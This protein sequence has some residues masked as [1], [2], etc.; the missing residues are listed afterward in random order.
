[1]IRSFP[2]ISR[3][4]TILAF[5]LASQIGAPVAANADVAAPTTCTVAGME[6]YRDPI[7]VSSLHPSY[8]G[9]SIREVACAVEST[10]SLRAGD[11]GI[12]FTFGRLYSER[13]GGPLLGV[14]L[15]TIE[16]IDA[17]GAIMVGRVLLGPDPLT[18]EMTFEPQVKALG[19]GIV[20][21]LSRRHRWI[22]ELKDTKLSS[23]MAFGWRSH[24]T[25]AFPDG[26]S[27]GANLSVDLDRMEG[28]VAVRA[29]SN[30][31]VPPFASTYG[32]NAVV[33]AKLGWRNGAL[34]AEDS[35]PTARKRGEE[36]F[37]D[38]IEEKDEAIRQTLK[39][40]PTGTEPCSLGAWS[41]DRDPEGLNVRAAPNAQARVLGVVP[42]PRKL[43]GEFG[44]E[45]FRSEFRIIGH[46]QGWFLIDEVRAPGVRYGATHPRSL[47]Q[48]IKGRGWVKSELVGAAYANG[49]LS[50]NSLYISPH[51]DAN[52]G[53]VL[54]ADG[55]PAMGGLPPSRILACS[56]AWGL[57][58]TK[59]GQRGWW[60][61]LCSNQVTNCS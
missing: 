39:G 55:N 1:M 15:V 59:E 37:L 30:S 46:Q 40:L 43:P 49:G 19:E 56:G 52:A 27:E 11:I 57:V 18:R 20:I 53:E 42:P 41:I 58:E 4:C 8:R 12:R 47:P 38:Q 24:L 9:G 25:D 48:S 33:V 17:N 14:R 21:R 7:F 10:Q 50:E 60:R 45:P 54:S 16:K 3:T 31:R 5:G 2:A 44:N 36:P 61:G 51:A 32:E 23:Q 29:Q 26:A 34:A 22:F 6:L 13:V 28:R 35:Q